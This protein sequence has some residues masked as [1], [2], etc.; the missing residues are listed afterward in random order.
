MRR[1][2]RS[3]SHRC[4]VRTAH[5]SAVHRRRPHAH[6]LAARMRRVVPLRERHDEPGAHDGD[7]H[8]DATHDAADPAQARLALLFGVRGERAAA[9]GALLG[10]RR[11]RAEARP[12]LHV[13]RQLH[14]LHQPAILHELP[15]IRVSRRPIL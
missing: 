7:G 1:S 15:P 9:L 5:H 12:P 10:V 6:L 14:R 11:V 3:N 2:V 4:S 8:D 13:H